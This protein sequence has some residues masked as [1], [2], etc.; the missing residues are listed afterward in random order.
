M[1]GN[2]D[3]NR[4]CIILITCHNLMPVVERGM[5]GTFSKQCDSL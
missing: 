1:L 3:G 2:T 4:D 5:C